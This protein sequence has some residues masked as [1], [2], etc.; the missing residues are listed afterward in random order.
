MG[1]PVMSPVVV[2]K[3]KPAGNAGLTVYEVTMPPA[4]DGSFSVIGAFTM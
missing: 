4:L 1:V 3:L 2:L